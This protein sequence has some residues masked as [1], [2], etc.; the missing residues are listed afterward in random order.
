MKQTVHLQEPLW[1]GEWAVDMEITPF[2]VGNI[3]A[4]RAVEDSF[5]ANCLIVK[6][7]SPA[8]AV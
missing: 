3:E 1:L 8:L 2:S 4:T 5:L 6:S 7:L